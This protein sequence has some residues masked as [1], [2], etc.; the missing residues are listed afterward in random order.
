VGRV[1]EGIC[2]PSTEIFLTFEW[3]MVHFGAFCVLFLP[4]HLPQWGG[5]CAPSSEIFLTSEWKMVHFGAFR[6]LGTIFG[7]LQ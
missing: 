1:A 7:R 6:N 2:S 3:K 4:P 5:V